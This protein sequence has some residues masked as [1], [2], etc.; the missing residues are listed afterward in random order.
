MDKPKYL[1]VNAVEF[2]DWIV[3]AMPGSGGDL[4]Q[5]STRNA[6]WDRSQDLYLT[7]RVFA[8]DYLDD[9][10]ACGGRPVRVKVRI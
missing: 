1:F 9:G 3:F 6:V 8:R 7:A 5:V 2:K 4:K 10:V